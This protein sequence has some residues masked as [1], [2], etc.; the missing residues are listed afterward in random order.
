M[1]LPLGSVTEI[2]IVEA[3]AF[4]LD[5]LDDLVY[6]VLGIGSR[7]AVIAGSDN[8][9]LSIVEAGANVVRKPLVSQVGEGDAVALGCQA[10]SI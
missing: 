3:I 6:A 10:R 7:A 8:Q 9:C 4:D 5:D 2:R 1:D